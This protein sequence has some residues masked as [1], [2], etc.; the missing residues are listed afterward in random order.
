MLFL[1]GFKR[2]PQTLRGSKAPKH[3]GSNKEHIAV[4][5]VSNAALVAGTG[6]IQTSC[7]NPLH[8]SESPQDFLSQRCFGRGDDTVGSPHRAQ[9]PPFE[10]FELVLLLKLGKQLPSSNSRRWYRS[11]QYPPPLKAPGPYSSSYYY[12]H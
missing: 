7:S 2:C 11:Q 6:L 4:L 10:L 8:R 9:V 12:Y 3:R 5:Y 1:H